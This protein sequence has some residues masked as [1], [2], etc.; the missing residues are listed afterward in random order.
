MA[1]NNSEIES[2]ETGTEKPKIIYVNTQPNIVS[3]PV[4]RPEEYLPIFTGDT[5]EDPE[6]FIQDVEK[7]FEDQNWQIG[8]REKCILLHRQLRGAAHKANAYYMHK[9]KDPQELYD[10]LIQN[11]GTESNFNTLRRK[12]ENMVF[13]GSTEEGRL[14][15]FIDR[16]SRL[17]KRLY[18]GATNSRLID[19]LIQTFP[20]SKRDAFVAADIQDNERLIRLAKKLLCNRNNFRRSENY[21][22]TP[23]MSP[24]GSRPSH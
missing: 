7:C 19:E 14:E 17:F 13:N 12:L 11:F 15:I 6:E 24:S 5:E 4:F 21:S 8:E 18:P 2:A 16:F 3:S 10:R 1:E 9:D 20:S 22:R 23:E